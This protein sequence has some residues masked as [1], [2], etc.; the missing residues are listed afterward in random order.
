MKYGDY[1]TKGQI[2]SQKIQ[3]NQQLSDED[4]K[5][6]AQ[7][8]MDPLG[9]FIKREAPFR[10]CEILKMEDQEVD[11]DTLDKAEEIIRD[12]IDFCDDLYD[13][14]DDDLRYELLDKDK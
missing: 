12:A 2:V 14:M 13:R 3:K 4:K 6:I 5:I 1:Q 11:E 9:E 7:V 8:M 10:I